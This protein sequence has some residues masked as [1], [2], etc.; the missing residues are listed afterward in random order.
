M[1]SSFSCVATGE[2]FRRIGVVLGD[3][4]RS[5][6]GIIVISSVNR[7]HQSHSSVDPILRRSFAHRH[8]MV[9]N[10]LGLKKQCANEFLLI[11]ENCSIRLNL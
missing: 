6:V 4:R 1:C 9:P 11:R 7:S 8:T 5:H 10:I 2:M 3:E